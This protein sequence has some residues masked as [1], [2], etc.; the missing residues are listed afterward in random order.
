MTQEDI[1]QHPEEYDLSIETV[2]T[3]TLKSPMKGVSFV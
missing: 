1:L 2:G 3:G